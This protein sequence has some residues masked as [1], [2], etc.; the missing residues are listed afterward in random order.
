VTNENIYGNLYAMGDKL[1]SEEPVR[2]SWHG[3]NQPKPRLPYY[4]R[5]SKRLKG[6]DEFEAPPWKGR[7]RFG[8]EGPV[9]LRGVVRETMQWLGTFVLVAMALG[10]FWYWLRGG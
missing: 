10:A 1:G 2:K 7:V 3:L 8:D 4:F 9:T 6:L 5:S